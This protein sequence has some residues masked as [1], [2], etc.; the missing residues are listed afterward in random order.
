V[1]IE[2]GARR[3]PVWSVRANGPPIGPRAHIRSSISCAAEGGSSAARSGDASSTA[4]IAAHP[5]R[6]INVTL[7]L[8]KFMPRR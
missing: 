6:R 3:L 7:G 5:R 4:P 2:V 8:R 1:E